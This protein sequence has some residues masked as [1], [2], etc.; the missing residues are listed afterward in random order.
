VENESGAEASPSSRLARSA[1]FNADWCPLLPNGE[2][3][4]G[5]PIDLLFVGLGA[6]AL[7]ALLL[8]SAEQRASFSQEIRPGSRKALTDAVFGRL[9]I[10]NAWAWAPAL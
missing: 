7:C 6:T 10:R 3:P 2:S 5:Q 4:V 9:S 1:I 8:Q